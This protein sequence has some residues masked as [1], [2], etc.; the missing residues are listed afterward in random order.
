MIEKIINAVIL[1]TIFS[2]IIFYPSELN[3]WLAASIFAIWIIVDII[4]KPT[5]TNIIT[6]LLF[7]F[8]AVILFTVF[9]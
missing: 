6:I 4:R 1:L 9:R 3:L 8:G 7:S 2:L 5:K